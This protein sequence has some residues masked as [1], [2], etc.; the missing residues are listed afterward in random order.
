MET[1]K[2]SIRRWSGSWTGLLN[3]ISFMKRLMRSTH[4]SY[5]LDDAL[6]MPKIGI[7]SKDVSLKFIDEN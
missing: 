7:E 1:G 3:N 2:S 4:L 5:K 6:H